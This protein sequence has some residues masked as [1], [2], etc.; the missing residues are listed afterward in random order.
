M[1]EFASLITLM[2]STRAECDKTIKMPVILE[3]IKADPPVPSPTCQTHITE[4]VQNVQEFMDAISKSDFI[5]AAGK[6]PKLYQN[7]QDIK[8]SCFNPG[9]TCQSAFTTMTNNI[10]LALTNFHQKDENIIKPAFHAAISSTITWINECVNSPAVSSQTNLTTRMLTKIVQKPVFATRLR[11][12]FAKAS[13]ILGDDQCDAALTTFCETVPKIFNDNPVSAVVDIGKAG[14]A[15][16]TISKC[17]DET[18]EC[19]DMLMKLDGPLGDLYN[20]FVA[21]E[22]DNS[23]ADM[24]K[25]L[26]IWLEWRGQCFHQ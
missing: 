20:H 24:D 16:H 11:R 1:N 8:T 10:N 14:L 4:T 3:L 13:T 5:G 7:W 26:D 19:D 17:H 22:I 15:A 9:P 23:N 12:F 21:L 6:L 18:Q 2:V 25:A